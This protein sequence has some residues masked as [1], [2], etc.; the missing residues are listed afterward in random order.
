ME[1]NKKKNA[2]VNSNDEKPTDKYKVNN[3]TIEDLLDKI[4]ITYGLPKNKIAEI[5]S[6]GKL[7]GNTVGGW[8]RWKASKIEKVE[9]LILFLWGG[10]CEG[11]ITTVDYAGE[12]VQK[13]FDE[14]YEYS[15]K[16]GDETEDFNTGL[17]KS[18]KK[19]QVEYNRLKDCFFERIKAYYL[20]IKGEKDK[21]IKVMT[22]KHDCYVKYEDVIEKIKKDFGFI[23]MENEEEEELIPKRSYQEGILNEKLA[24]M[25]ELSVLFCGNAMYTKEDEKSKRLFSEVREKTDMESIIKK[26][27]CLFRGY[28]IKKDL[29]K[30]EECYKKAIR[31]EDSME[32][33]WAYI[34]MAHLYR[35]KEKKT[36]NPSEKYDLQNKAKQYYRDAALKKNIIAQYEIET[37]ALAEYQDDP[38]M[39]WII[40][41]SENENADDMVRGWAYFVRAY[42]E[43]RY[44]KVEMY[45]DNNDIRNHILIFLKLAKQ[46]KE[47]RALYGF[48]EYYYHEDDNLAEK[49]YNEYKNE[50]LAHESEEREFIS[51]ALYKLGEINLRK[52]YNDIEIYNLFYEA[53]RRGHEDASY[54]MGEYYERVQEYDLALEYYLYAIFNVS[55]YF[56]DA[57]NNVCRIYKEEIQ[58][59]YISLECA[60]EELA[61]LKEY[62][63][64]G[65]IEV[66]IG[67]LLLLDN[68]V[69]N[70]VEI[71]EN[72]AEAY[73]K[74][75][76]EALDELP[77]LIDE[78]YPRIKKKKDKKKIIKLLEEISSERTH[79][80]KKVVELYC[81]EKEGE[82]KAYKFL[83][84]EIKNDNP[85]AY[86]ELGNLYRILAK[87]KSIV[88]KIDAPQNT[89]YYSALKPET[90]RYY[91]LKAADMGSVEACMK[92][93]ESYAGEGNREEEKDWLEEAADMGSVEAC[94]KLAERC[95]GEGKQGEEKKWLEKAVDMGS[96]EACVKL[97]ERCAGKGKQ[98]EEKKWLEKAVDMGS[99][100]ACVKL[101]E[102]CAGKGKQG[103]EKKWLEKAVDMGSVEACMKL[104]ESYAEEGNR[105]EE[106]A[107][108]EEAVSMGSVEAFMKLEENYA[109]EKNCV[110]E[111]ECLKKATDMCSVEMRQDS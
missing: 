8:T 109:E 43:I 108:L 11:K 7:K 60:L 40:D 99:V 58:K 88:H 72:Y 52:G 48:G 49:Y 9:M 33:S 34:N 47:P 105:E 26:G 67:E 3:S 4:Q 111:G 15:K 5:I 45:K 94:M 29:D 101:A 102:R 57:L 31:T 12:Q 16:F 77:K 80:T 106:K 62:S 74:E 55:I 91:Y 30:A 63:E 39:K 25:S 92:L 71:L 87:G 78:L 50:I 1:E 37:A 89:E 21:K 85:V 104:A 86:V 22:P 110:K 35:E 83:Q 100:E 53:A 24:Y 18:I 54:R 56:H 27:N 32:K 66:G 46:Y 107:W 90:Y 41:T 73:K 98:G 61:K 64:K 17:K 6:D 103:E 70:S 14:L 76:V 19:N 23:I 95:A 28:G 59:N 81:M 42:Y 96:V 75:N 65:E 79:I 10:I 84:N 36:A 38:T 69:D 82:E 2:T 13:H 44:I 68:P 51:D 93:A 97:A 20:E